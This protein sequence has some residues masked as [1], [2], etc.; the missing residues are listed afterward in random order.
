[1]IE[2]AQA[3]DNLDAILDVPG[4]DAVYIGPSDLSFS[5]GLAPRLDREEPEFVQHLRRVLHATGRRGIAPG[6]H[7]IDPAYA[8]KAVGMGFRLVT[9]NSDSGLM[10]QAA[11]AAVEVA[12][13]RSVP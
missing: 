2:T 10:L 11:R 4:I 8:A 6:I 7:C 12:R 3:L 13:G 9:C 1:M 5:L